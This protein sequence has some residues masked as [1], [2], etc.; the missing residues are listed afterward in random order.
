MREALIAKD[1]PPPALAIIMNSWRNGTKKQYGVYLK[2]WQEFC[3]LKDI[4]MT[5]T[6]I[7]DVLAFLASLK[8]SGL[9]YSAINTARGALSA[10]LTISKRDTI[11]SHPLVVRFMKGVFESCPPQPRYTSTW[12]VGIVLNYL[13]TQSPVRRL[14]LKRLTLKL[15]ML[16]ALVTAQ[17][18]QTLQLLDLDRLTRGKHF[19]F[20]FSEPLKQSRQGKPAFTLD[21]LPYP[22]DRRLCVLTV[23]NEYVLR[24]VSCRGNET[25]LLLS[26]TR[27]HAKVSR[28]T[29]ARWI[30][31]VMAEAGVD[32]AVFKA[33]STRA[34]ATSKAASLHVPVDQILKVGGWSTAGTFGRFYKKPVEVK[35]FA[36]TILDN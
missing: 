17:R 36:S 26:F 10:L 28:D 4:N 29:I 3:I 14:T 23:L 22:P 21:L 1:V 9:G 31:T 8:S 13:K 24:T 18:V 32:T 2:K 27:P 12:D 25:A 20:S 7:N 6:R 35:R 15:T 5:F 11:G 16:L 19:S 34:A 33:H 30:R